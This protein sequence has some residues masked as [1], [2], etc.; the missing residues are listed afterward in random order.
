MLIQRLKSHF[1]LPQQ[2]Q[3]LHEILWTR[4]LH[5]PW[6]LRLLHGLKFQAESATMVWKQ[7]LVLWV[8]LVLTYNSPFSKSR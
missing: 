2:L 1:L 5:K 8:Y 6:P 4:L 7:A 3:G